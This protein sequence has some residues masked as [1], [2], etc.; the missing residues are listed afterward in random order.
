MPSRLGL[1]VSAPNLNDILL[2][3]HLLY[4]LVACLE[5]IAHHMMLPM[6]N[7]PIQVK[8][9]MEGGACQGGATLTTHT[10]CL[11]QLTYIST[12]K[13]HTPAGI[14]RGPNSVW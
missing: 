6:G 10:G 14:G 2:Q 13:V 11:N 4:T 8:S 9:H 12:L 5:T 7:C 3:L 1:S